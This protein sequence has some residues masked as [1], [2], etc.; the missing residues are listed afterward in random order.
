MSPWG[1]EK[2][3]EVLFAIFVTAWWQI[4]PALKARQ[5]HVEVEHADKESLKESMEKSPHSLSPSDSYT[6]SC[7]H[8]QGEH[9]A[10][11][12]GFSLDMLSE[13]GGI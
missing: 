2:L 10:T 11:F 6:Q 13:P 8:K 12:A 4:P 7:S 5:Y 9:L 3:S 1:S